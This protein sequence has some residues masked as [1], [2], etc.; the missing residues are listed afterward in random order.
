MGLMSIS[1]WAQ[2]RVLK[3]EERIC[4][5]SIVHHPLFAPISDREGDAAGAGQQRT[6]SRGDPGQDDA[7]AKSDAR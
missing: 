2:R 1:S 3:K 4:T 5:N 6:L 7:A